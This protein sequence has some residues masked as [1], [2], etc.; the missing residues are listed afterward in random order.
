[1]IYIHNARILTPSARI[2]DGAV[3]VEDERVALVGP[4]AQIP[5]PLAA[6]IV[7]G[8]GGTL[9]P[10][11]IDLQLNGAF[12]FDFTD[13]PQSIWQA[14]SRLPQYGVTAFLPTV[15]TSPLQTVEHAQSVVLQS[16]P[17]GYAGATPIGLH[18]EG[19]FLNPQ[20]RGAHNPVHLRPPDLATIQDWRPERGVRL[21]TLAPELPGALD[22][23]R[24]LAQR[25]VVVSVGHSLAD[26]EQTRTTIEAGARY[27][28]HLFNAMPA[29]DHRQP[30][31]IGALLEDTR[32]TVGLLVDGIHLHPAI[33][34]LVA[35]AA[36]AG[37]LS[38]VTDAMAALGM[39]D[40]TY[41]LGDMEVRVS[42]GEARLADGRLA[43]SLLSLDQALRNLMKFAGV[44]LEEAVL[45][46]TQ[47]PANLLGLAGQ[48]GCIAPG[49]RADLV[50][51]TP[52]L[53]VAATIA[54][55]KIIY[56]RP[57]Q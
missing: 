15:I 37:R 32:V 25:G 13:Q 51:L 30:G 19:P 17:P 56:T 29:L 2:E 57:K 47:V 39:P 18:L 11:F 21:A 38:L 14:G 31:L 34:S 6:Q 52:E 33:V 40:G 16:S 8:R 36:G 22:L 27:A 49:A 3:L 45:A 24:S 46:V 53:K 5:R 28:T 48:L 4:R 9:A 10:G 43:G 42:S 23:V 26:Y 55:G 20:K 7:D 12:G 44:P 41:R 1:M 54:G 35:R 50:L